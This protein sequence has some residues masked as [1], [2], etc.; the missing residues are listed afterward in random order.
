M[1]VPQS[2]VAANLWHKEEGER[3][4]KPTQ[5]KRK[6][7]RPAFSSPAEI[8]AMLKETNTS[9]K[10]KARLII[11][12][13]V[14]L[15]T[16]LHR[17]RA[18]PRQPPLCDNNILTSL[19]SGFISGDS[20]VNQLTYLCN[21]ICQALDHGKEVRAVFCDISKDFDRVW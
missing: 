12:R 17:V 3:D 8:I 13:L 16:K 6:A 4:N 21:I 11:N 20:T 9:T 14:E 10:H 5:N 15:A 18:T 19:Q 1:G 2:Q 7:H